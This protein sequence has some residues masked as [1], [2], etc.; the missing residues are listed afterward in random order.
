MRN[1]HSTEM[2]SRIYIADI[3]QY[4]NDRLKCFTQCMELKEL[5]WLVK[6][7]LTAEIR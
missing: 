5:F 3:S 4:F 1:Y 6:S 7:I 2:V